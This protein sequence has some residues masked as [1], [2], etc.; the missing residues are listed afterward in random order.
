MFIHTN[1]GVITCVMPYIVMPYVAMAYVAMAYVSIAYIV[2]AYIVMAYIVM[3]YT[4]MAYTVMVLVSMTQMP[5]HR[6][7]GSRLGHGLN[8]YFRRYRAAEGPT[9]RIPI[10]TEVPLWHA[11][12]FIVA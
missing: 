11:C 2:I 4:V 5:T 7:S 9:L 10:V 6:H 1:G 3:A 8:A 12:A